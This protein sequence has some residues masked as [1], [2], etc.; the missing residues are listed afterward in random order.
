MSFK[1]LNGKC[2]LR[3]RWLK[4]MMTK[5]IGILAVIAVVV[6]CLLTFYFRGSFGHYIFVLIGCLYVVLPLLILTGI[7]FCVSFLE[8]KGRLRRVS[9]NFFLV[10]LLLGSTV[11]SVII[12][13]QL[14][15]HD[16]A[17]AKSF[18][19]E[20]VPELDIYQL[21]HGAYPKSIETLVGNRK[22]PVILR[23]VGAFYHSDGDN[24]SFNFMD[25]SKLMVGFEFWSERRQW[26]RW[27]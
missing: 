15:R 19:E 3:S 2:Q 26:H 22:L 21:E 4:K 11:V 8:P 23:R 5:K 14:T 24:F 18:C 13:I 25:P 27:D 6:N 12:G 9:I 7:L 16:I 20:L 17:E 1:R 10:S